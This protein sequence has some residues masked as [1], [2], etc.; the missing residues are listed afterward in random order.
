LRHENPDVRARTSRSESNG[1]LDLILVVH[2]Q[3]GWR[4]SA[5]EGHF[6]YLAVI[7]LSDGEKRGRIAG[8]TRLLKGSDSRIRNSSRPAAES[9]RK[10]CPSFGVNGTS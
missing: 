10:Q 6:R 7:V 8:I 1:S 4:A 5:L 2:V 9:V 3:V